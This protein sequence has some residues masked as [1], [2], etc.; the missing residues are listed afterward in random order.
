[1][2][3]ILSIFLTVLS[4]VFAIII[5]MDRRK[6]FFTNPLRLFYM[7]AIQDYNSLRKVKTVR[8]ISCGAGRERNGSAL[9]WRRSS[10]FLCR[11]A[12]PKQY[13]RMG[14]C[15]FYKKTIMIEGGSSQ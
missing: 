1:M 6:P 12:T 2:D 3:D 5:F 4:R 9:P 15:L 14:R 11:K 13:V 10:L 8:A 7:G